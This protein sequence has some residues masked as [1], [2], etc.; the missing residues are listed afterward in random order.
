[1]KNEEKREKVRGWKVGKEENLKEE[2]LRKS[3]Q[4]EREK[5]LAKVQNNISSELRPHKCLNP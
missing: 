1:M 3:K 4:R 5:K 2:R